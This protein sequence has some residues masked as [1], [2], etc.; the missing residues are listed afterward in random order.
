MLDLLLRGG[1]LTEAE[2]RALPIDL[3]VEITDHR[4]DRSRSL[5]DVTSMSR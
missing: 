3:N 5:P 2:A 4:T 1:Y